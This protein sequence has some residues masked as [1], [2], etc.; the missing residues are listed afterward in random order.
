MTWLLAYSALGLQM[1]PEESLRENRTIFVSA[2]LP[3]DME[4]FNASRK[5][6]VAG[7][8]SMI[9]RWWPSGY[10]YMQ[11]ATLFLECGVVGLK[12]DKRRATYERRSRK[13]GNS[14]LWLPR[15]PPG[16]E[17]PPFLAVRVGQKGSSVTFGGQ[18]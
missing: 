3:E 16:Q 5:A 17:D 14:L 4:S 10:I 7:M 2:N 13:A 18:R 12:P 11:G 6:S 15:P 1:V 8:A 9:V